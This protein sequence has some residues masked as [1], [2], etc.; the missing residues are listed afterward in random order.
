MPAQADDTSLLGMILQTEALLSDLVLS[1]F[2]KPPYSP[3]PS[4]RPPALCLCVER[5][6]SP[7]KRGVLSLQCEVPRLSPAQDALWICSSVQLEGEV[8]QGP[9]GH[10][11]VRTCS[12]FCSL[13]WN[14][15]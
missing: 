14:T 2:P 13:L 15:L 10:E 8:G 4:V 6:L 7:Q 3:D 1:L 11:A 5:D 12:T 9:D